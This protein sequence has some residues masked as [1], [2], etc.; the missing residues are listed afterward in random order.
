MPEGRYAM[1]MVSV[2]D[3]LHVVGGEGKQSTFTPSKYFFQQDEWQSFENP[4]PEG[5]SYL[6]MAGIE[7]RLYAMGGRVEQVFTGQNLS[8]QAIFTIA[9]P[10]VR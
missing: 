7:T 6:G 5:W 2:A 9:V 3:I 10:V 1:G 8:Y 4:V